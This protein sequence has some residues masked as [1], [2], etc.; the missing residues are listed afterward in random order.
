MNCNYIHKYGNK[1]TYCHKACQTEFCD[2]HSHVIFHPKSP[3]EYLK[4]G[5]SEYDEIVEWIREH[6]QNID[7]ESPLT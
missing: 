2:F 1:G 6:P 7:D 5:I 4:N 3:K